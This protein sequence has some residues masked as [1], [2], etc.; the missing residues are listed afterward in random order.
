M[1]NDIELG[2][3]KAQRDDALRLCSS[4]IEA[5]QKIFQGD[6]EENLGE[7]ELGFEMLKTAGDRYYEWAKPLLDSEV[8]NV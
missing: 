3:I 1:K 5:V 4:F 7:V 2:V 8:N 6:R